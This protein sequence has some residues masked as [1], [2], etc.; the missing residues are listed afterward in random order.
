VKSFF[1]KPERSP[2]RCCLSIALFRVPPNLAP[3]PL[4][5]SEYYFPWPGFITRTHPPLRQSLCHMLLLFLC[6]HGTPKPSPFSDRRRCRTDYSPVVH[7]P[8]FF[9]S[10]A[11]SYI[12]FLSFPRPWQTSKLLH[13]SHPPSAMTTSFSFLPPPQYGNGGQLL[14][15]FPQ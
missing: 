12:F 8:P 14:V 4:S 5:L 2:P 6:A 13:M 7:S 1:G 10:S 3:P 15:F 9:P 11:V